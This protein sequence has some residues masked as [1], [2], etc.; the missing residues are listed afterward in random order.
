MPNPDEFGRYR[1]AEVVGGKTRHYS[2]SRYLPGVHA[3]VQGPDAAA[4]YDNGQE[5]PPKFNVAEPTPPN[6]PNKTTPK[7]A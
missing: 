6:P 2:T 5:R 3:I 1:V 7:G 4:S